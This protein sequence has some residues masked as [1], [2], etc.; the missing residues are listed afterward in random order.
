MT[1]TDQL[2]IY[3]TAYQ[4]NVV[5]RCTHHD[6]STELL[7][8][9]APACAELSRALGYDL[10]QETLKAALKRFSSRLPH[11][12]PT[13]PKVA[14][15]QQ[16]QETERLKHAAD[17]QRLQTAKAYHAAKGARKAVA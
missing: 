14:A 10:T 9:V 13:D 3:A 17:R 1:Y 4:Y 12:W 6:N 15:D 5:G 2:N 16:S 11:E 7:M 8:P